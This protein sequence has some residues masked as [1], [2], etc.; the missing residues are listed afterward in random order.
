M[1]KERDS[2]KNHLLSRR[3]FSHSGH[4]KW[5]Y[6]ILERRE[7]TSR[8]TSSLSVLTCT[9]SL[10][11]DTGEEEVIAY[12][13]FD[14]TNSTHRVISNEILRMLHKNKDEIMSDYGLKIRRP[15]LTQI[16]RALTFGKSFRIGFEKL[17]AS[18]F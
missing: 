11:D 6:L 8:F 18:F 16:A 9:L 10:I 7:E 14:K 3:F 2:R 17:E 4:G 13:E 1:K 12:L 5:K 15:L